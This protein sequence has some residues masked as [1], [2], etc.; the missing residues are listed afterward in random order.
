M[1]IELTALKAL[2]YDFPVGTILRYLSE[3]ED[4]D[5]SWFSNELTLVIHAHNEMMH[6]EEVDSI[7]SLVNDDWIRKSKPIS[8]KGLV[9]GSF[10]VLHRCSE[11][12]LMN[13]GGDVKVRFS[14][15]LRWN[16]FVRLIGEDLFV[17]IYRAA[18]KMGSD[19]FAW[20][21]VISC[22]GGVIDEIVEDKL[23]DIHTHLGGAGNQFILNWLSVINGAFLNDEMFAALNVSK[24]YEQRKQKYTNLRLW[25]VVAA[26]IRY[27]L[28]KKLILKQPESFGDSFTNDLELIMGK[29]SDFLKARNK[30]NTLVGLKR[31]LSRKTTENTFIDYAIVPDCDD[32]RVSSP[33]MIHHGERRLLYLFLYGYLRNEKEMAKIA[34]FVYL[35]CLIKNHFRKELLLISAHRGLWNFNQTL[36]RKRCFVFPDMQRI[37]LKYAYQTSIRKDKNDSAELRVN[38]GDENFVMLRDGSLNQCIFSDNRFFDKTQQQKITYLV[39]LSKGQFKNLNNNGR[40]QRAIVQKV[41]E[42][43]FFCE[44]KNITGID[45]AGN[46][47]ETSP[48]R[49]GHYYRYL[50]ARGHRNFTYHVGEDFYDIIDGLRHIDEVMVFL[51]AGEGW[52]LGHCVA[53]GIEPELFYHRKRNHIVMPKQVLL[54]NLVWIICRSRTLHVNIPSDL[55]L[56]MLKEISNLYNDIGFEA[57]F[58]LSAYYQSLWLRSDVTGILEPES[59]KQIAWESS[60][61]CQHPFCVEARNNPEA[62]KLAYKDRLTLKNAQEGRKAVKWKASKDYQDVVTRLQKTMLSIIK[63]SDITIE[64]NPTSNLMVCML[65]RYAN[66]PV[67][68]FRDPYRFWRKRIAVT[69][70]T[71]DKGVFGTSMENE[72][73]LLTRSLEKQEGFFEG[74]KYRE[75]LIKR[76]MMYVIAEGRE[77]KFKWENNQ[78]E[79]NR[80]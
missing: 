33:Y 3:M 61:K 59:N 68:K 39:H 47:I 24:T 66:E 44:D 10:K 63:E 78:Y 58:S 71:D 51:G 55:Q 36:Y 62:V 73:A 75:W 13:D 80:Y 42:E 43:G 76:H 15:I 23:C 19:S 1:D 32:A 5:A 53:L 56:T 20:N 18:H 28:Y 72:I 26:R 50:H 41:L 69:V 27:E 16:S 17:C 9:E 22:K 21:D 8:F 38:V 46:E 30:L 74:T 64:C 12:M 65:G 70:N 67:F 37:L 6:K 60:M 29:E 49:L 40:K 31:Q 14:E 2:F 45:A 35:Y 52:R 34:R 79:A 48:D 25:S 57:S 77:K 7:I 11:M 4:K 54:D